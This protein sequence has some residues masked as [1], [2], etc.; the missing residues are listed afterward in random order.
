MNSSST[1]S[2]CREGLNTYKVCSL[3]TLT[4]LHSSTWATKWF[5]RLVAYAKCNR[6]SYETIQEMHRMRC[7]DAIQAA[8]KHPKPV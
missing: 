3:E 5:K 7:W 4:R 2:M 1:F 6:D 8:K